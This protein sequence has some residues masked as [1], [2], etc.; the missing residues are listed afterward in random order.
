MKIQNKKLRTVAI[1]LALVGLLSL[2]FTLGFLWRTR[3]WENTAKVQTHG[4]FTL[5]TDASFS[6]SFSSE[7]GTFS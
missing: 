4:D 7:N 2:T 6:T 5:W 3:T 1:A